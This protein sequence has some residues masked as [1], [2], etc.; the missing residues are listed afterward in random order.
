MLV[1]KVVNDS[2]DFFK[3]NNKKRKINDNVNLL[4]NEGGRTL[5]RE[6]TEKAVTECLLFI[7]LHWQHHP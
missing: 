4:L 1:A 5:V 3:Y 6:D 2:K 7:D